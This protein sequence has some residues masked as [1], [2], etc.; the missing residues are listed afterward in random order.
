M[1]VVFQR[2]TWL[3]IP[4]YRNLLKKYMY[5]FSELKKKLESIHFLKKVLHCCNI[6]SIAKGYILLKFNSLYSICEGKYYILKSYIIL[7]KPGYRYNNS[8][9]KVIHN[10]LPDFR[11][12]QRNNQDRCSRKDHISRHKI[13]SSLFG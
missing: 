9:C 10:S 4:G 1:S 13:S 6:L 2:T 7:C 8:I 3:Y 12:R 5:I 11:T